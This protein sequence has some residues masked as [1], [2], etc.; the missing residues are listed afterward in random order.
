[1]G[2][3]YRACYWRSADGQREVRLTGPEHAAYTEAHLL[4]VALKEVRDTGL[5]I[6]DGN[7]EIG[8]WTHG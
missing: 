6:G 8:E 1:M 2:E 4:V 7:I 5:E 3:S